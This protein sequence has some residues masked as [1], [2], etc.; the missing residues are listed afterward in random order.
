M[1]GVNQVSQPVL[2]AALRHAPTGIGICDDDGRFL[3]VNTALTRLLGR[4]ANQILGHPFLNFVHPAQRP[5]ALAG[6]F[7]AV[8]AS[9]AGLRHGERRLRCLS[10]DGG[11]ISVL[12]SWTVTDPDENGTSYGITYLTADAD[13]QRRRLSTRAET[14]PGPAPA[15]ASCQR[16]STP[17]RLGT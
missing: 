17:S 4:P 7:E 14:A 8:V 9:A 15:L 5:A 2:A 6:Y 13:R 11:A 10:G 3:A 12:V 1:H 16:P